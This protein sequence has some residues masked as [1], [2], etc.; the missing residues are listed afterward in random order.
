MGSEIETLVIHLARAEGR[1]AQVEKLLQGT[2]YPARVLAAVDGA[3]V[4]VAERNTAI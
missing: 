4:P 3:I 1:R 2:P